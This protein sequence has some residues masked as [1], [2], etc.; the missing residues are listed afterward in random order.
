MSGH[1]LFFQRIASGV[2]WF[3]RST[4]LSCSYRIR[5]YSCTDVG[6][7]SLKQPAIVFDIRS[8]TWD[9]C[10]VTLG[11]YELYCYSGD[12]PTR[13]QR[14][15]DLNKKNESGRVGMSG[16]KSPRHAPWTEPLIRR[17]KQ[18][19]QQP[20][21]PITPTSRHQMYIFYLI[22]GLHSFYRITMSLNK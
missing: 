11:Q 8:L 6:R 7:G 2:P 9:D 10:P 13:E 22:N 19:T 3:L 5:H 15:H 4:V 17:V 20:P 16:G 21:C 1:S 14:D 18:N 12:Y